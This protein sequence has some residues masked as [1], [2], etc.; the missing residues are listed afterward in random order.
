MNPTAS[1]LP[2]AFRVLC[3]RCNDRV[4]RARSPAC[5]RCG[6]YLD[7]D[8]WQLA[9]TNWILEAIPGVWFSATVIFVAWVALRCLAAVS[10]SAFVM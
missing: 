7:R 5:G 4:D 1:G 9:V 3:H 10:R 8:P 2:I 6:C